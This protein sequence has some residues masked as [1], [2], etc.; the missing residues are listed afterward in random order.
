MEDRE[1][2]VP[3]EADGN[4]LALATTKGTLSLLPYVGGLLSAWTDVF[5]TPPLQQRLQ[6]WR[7]E[8]AGGLR[9]LEVQI[10]GLHQ[11]F[12]SDE[13]FTSAGII[14][15]RHAA[16]THSEE[17]RAALVAALLNTAKGVSIEDAEHHGFLRYL[18]Q[19]TEWHIRLLRMI[20]HTMTTNSIQPEEPQGAEMSGVM[21]LVEHTYPELVGK[22]VSYGPILKELQNEGLITYG[23]NKVGN[24]VTS[25]SLSITDRGSRFRSFI[26]NPISAEAPEAP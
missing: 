5:I 8:V 18:G 20:R 9:L 26:T 25:V 23:A 14:L 15:T 21:A 2:Y 13:R 3:P 7:N 10:E 19:C 4:D 6:D 1:K 22:R 12:A 11:R 24:N 17:V 16:E